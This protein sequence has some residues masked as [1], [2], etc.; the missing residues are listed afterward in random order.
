MSKW[1]SVLLSFTSAK[2]KNIVYSGTKLYWFIKKK[3]NKTKSFVDYNFKE[4]KW[5]KNQ[6]EASC[7]QFESYKS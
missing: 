1:S 4:K 6:L 5:E 2:K 3:K 7:H